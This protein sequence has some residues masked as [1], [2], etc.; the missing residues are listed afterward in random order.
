VARRHRGDADLGLNA[1]RFSIAWSRILPSGTGTV[2]ERGLDFY[3]QLVDGL[4]EAGITPNATLYHWDLPE[5]WTIAAAG[6]T[7]TPPTGSP[8]TRA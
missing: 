1:Y 3:R 6:S 8:T 5:R 2:N 7:A 4:L